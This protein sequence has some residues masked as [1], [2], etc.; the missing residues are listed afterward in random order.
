MSRALGSLR[1][2]LVALTGKF[3]A[4]FRSAVGALDKFGVAASKIG[5]VAAGAFNKISSVFSRIRNAVLSVE[6]ILSGAIVALGT[7]KI[8]SAFNEAAEAV[9]N[10]GKK[11]KTFGVAIED[12]SA[13]RFAAGES[14]VDFETLSK[15]VGKATKNVATFASTGGGPAADAI[16]RLG[17][18]FRSADG[19]LRSMTD[20]LPDI[21]TSLEGI[22]DQGERLRLSEGLFGREG[23]QQFVQFLEDSGGFMANLAD[24]TKRAADLGV[25][26]TER[27]FDKLKAYNDALGRISESWLGIRVRIMT[28]VAPALTRV[29][30]MLAVKMAEVGRFAGN[31]ASVIVAAVNRED[32]FQGTNEPPMNMALLA[33]KSLVLDFISALGN[34]VQT[35]IRYFFS[36]VWETIRVT[37]VDLLGRVGEFLTG[38]VEGVAGFI[39]EAFKAVVPIVAKF[40]KMIADALGG[41]GNYLADKWAEAG[42]NLEGYAA[43]LE[44]TRAQSWEFFSLSIDR[45]D[46]LGEKYRGLRGDVEKT[47]D[48]MKAGPGGGAPTQWDEFF[49]GMKAGFQDLKDEANDFAALGKNVFSTLSHGIASGLAS[50]LAKGEAS[51]RNFG[52]TALAVVGDVLQNVS[53]MIL[54]FLFYRAIV[55]AVGGAFTA[56]PAV[57]G[58]GSGGIPSFG[59]APP[60]YA[61]KGGAFGFASGGVAAGILPGPTGFSFSRRLGVAGERGRGTEAAFAPLRKIGGELGVGAV[62][63]ETVVQIIDQRQ[64]GERPSVEQGRGQ[65]GK[66]FIRVLI[67]DEVKRAI[68][69]GDLD[70]S[71]KASYG[72]QRRGT[73]R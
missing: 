23:G 30:D 29:A 26:F 13:L 43:E 56:T 10:L 55:G 47:R 19:S 12:L 20:L 68:G 52:K 35:R 32:I 71:L 42:K 39:G 48:A 8:A 73:G 49:A 72:L 28:E 31:L 16:R 64:Q 53:E 63:A 62:P 9:D 24:Q 46:R 34:E 66:R 36:R 27:Q 61:A 50:A 40:A 67:R 18:N 70:R 69:E 7:A 22:G 6:G 59:G 15:M 45:I 25:I 51:F 17:L 1:I 14:G 57:G 58:G 11:A 21:A 4:N 5:G 44:D 60:T 37:M 3:E 54:Q 38:A 65:D 2:D 33:L 41:A